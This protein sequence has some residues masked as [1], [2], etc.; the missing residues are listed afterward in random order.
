MSSDAIE[1]ADFGHGGPIDSSPLSQSNQQGQL[2]H[3]HDID[4]DHHAPSNGNGR[5]TSD[6]RRSESVMSQSQTLTPSRGGTLKKRQSLS[7]KVSQKQNVSRRNSYAGS[8]KG[9]VFAEGEKHRSAERDE[10]NSAFF[11]PVPTTG[12]PTEILANRFQG[13]ELIR[14]VSWIHANPMQ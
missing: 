9:L 12:N 5:I 11:T 4:N 14:I 8:E 13:M 1:A 10:L 6:P 3:I 2:A 7:R